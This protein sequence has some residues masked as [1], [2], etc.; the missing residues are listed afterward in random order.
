MRFDIHKVRTY[1]INEFNEAT[2]T[3]A[4]IDHDGTDIILLELYSGE[5]VIVHL[6]DR[7]MSIGEIRDTLS[8]NTVAKRHSLFILW[9]D[10]LLP[11]ENRDHVPEDWMEVLMTLYQGKIYGYDSYGPYASVFPV[12]F[13]NKGSGLEYYVT[14]GNAIDAVHLRCDTVHMDT[15]YLK[16]FYR[17][18]DFSAQAAGSSKRRTQGE[19]QGPPLNFHRNSLAAYFAVLE[20]P[21]TSD[22]GAVRRAYYQLARRYHPDINDSPDSTLRMQQINEAYKRIMEQFEKDA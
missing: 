21:S 9:S 10:M 6:V 14:Y 5:A 19:R 18:A 13:R 11:Q 17:I 3:V 2:D 20:I 4:R 1:L 8:E 12:Y 22:R 7:V 16:G 15:R